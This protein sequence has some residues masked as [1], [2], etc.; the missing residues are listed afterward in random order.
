M[1]FNTQLVN[2]YLDK[3]GNL[4]TVTAGTATAMNAV[5][6]NDVMY[7]TLS[8]RIALTAATN[9]ITL[10]M[11]WEVSDDNSTWE[12]CLLEGQDVTAALTDIVLTTGTAAIKTFHAAAPRAA[13]G[14]R[15]CRVSIVVGVTTGAAGDLYDVK[16]D[17]ARRD[18]AD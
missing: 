2:N 9:T 14:K 6:M 18:F 15:Y 17:Y 3:S 10:A 12:S 4:N 8:A 1:A 5:L 13:Y 7:G 11:R 16:Y